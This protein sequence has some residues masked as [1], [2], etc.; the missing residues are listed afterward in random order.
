LIHNLYID[1]AYNDEN[2]IY[3]TE[4]AQHMKHIFINKIKRNQWLE[5]KTKKYAIYKLENINFEIGSEKYKINSKLFPLLD[6]KQDRF[7]ENVLKISQWRHETYVKGDIDLLNTFI[8]CDYKSYPYKITNMQSYIV[9]AQYLFDKNLIK[10]TTAYLQKPF[11][12]IKDHGL[13]YNLAYIGFTIAHE[14]CHSLDNLGSQYDANGNTKNWWGKK[15][16]EMF[17]KIQQEIIKRN[18]EVSLNDG[19]YFDPKFTVGENIADIS[20]LNL[21]EEYLRNFC[22]HSNFTHFIT[23]L[24]FRMF[25]V[26]FTYQM[27]QKIKQQS[28]NYEINTDVHSIAKYRTNLALSSSK[29][30]KSLNNI[31]KNDKMYWD[32]KHSSIWE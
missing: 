24:Q 18:N 20:G 12:D 23:Y 22:I 21:C 5:E 31:Q 3:S 14:L 30:F 27:K 13:S 8:Q 16:K 7:L 26:Y 10:I 29:F 2:I 25:Y 32:D 19:F 4:I 11:I 9:N 28:I 1:Y 17:K 15:D 6:F